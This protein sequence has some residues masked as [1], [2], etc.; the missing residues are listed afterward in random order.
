MWPWT[1]GIGEGAEDEEMSEGGGEH[2]PSYEGTE[3]NCS[4]GSELFPFLREATQTF[5][6]SVFS[7]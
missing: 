3:E 6:A 5:S 2:E 1:K 7:L 4:F